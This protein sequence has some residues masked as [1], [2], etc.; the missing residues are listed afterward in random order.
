MTTSSRFKCEIAK[1]RLAI[2]I[3]ATK[4]AFGFFGESSEPVFLHEEPTPLTD[5]QSFIDMLQ[6]N[7]VSIEEKFETISDLGISVAGTVDPRTGIVACANVPS[8]SQ[9][10]LEKAIEE[11]M[12]KPVFLK[13]DAECLALAEALQ[14]RGQSYRIVFAIILGSGIGGAIV[15]DS[16]LLSGAT[17]QIGE[18]GHGNAI[19][20]LVE[21][22][23]LESRQCGDGRRNCLD[24]FGAGLGMSNIHQDLYGKRL[25]ARDI[26]AL[27]HDE[28]AAA[29]KTV[30]TY[31]DIVSSQLALV[32]NVID[33]DIVPVAG[34]LSNDARLIAELDIATRAQ[35]L[36]RIER[37][38]IVP[39]ELK[40]YGCLLG[41]AMLDAA[42]TAD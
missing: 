36:G 34:G 8:I 41:A 25:D 35:T 22:H 12:G 13:N 32:I 11:L 15:I 26:L 1:L 42:N 38:L 7:I 33:P 3:G 14:G 20:H 19:D 16:G 2:D 31:I 37:P 18:W 23:G 28:D 24:L 21:K 30:A 40:E 9:R 5:W 27:W 6:R 4:T 29:A 17:G 10:S 39:A